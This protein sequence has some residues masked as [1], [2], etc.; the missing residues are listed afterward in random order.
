MNKKK[1]KM[2]KLGLSVDAIS[3]HG[4]KGKTSVEGEKKCGKDELEKCSMKKC[5]SKLEKCSD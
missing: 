5:K 2:E 3:S 4:T 1:S